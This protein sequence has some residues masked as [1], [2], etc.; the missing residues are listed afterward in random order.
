MTILMCILLAIIIISDYEYATWI[1]YA[2][3]LCI[4]S[5]T[6]TYEVDLVLIDLDLKLN[7]CPTQVMKEAWVHSITFVSFSIVAFAIFVHSI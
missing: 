1:N 7:P 5:N 2:A 6:C 4:L 3:I